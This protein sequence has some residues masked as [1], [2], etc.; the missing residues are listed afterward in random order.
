MNRQQAV[1]FLQTWDPDGPVELPDALV[2]VLETDTE[3]QAAFDARFARAPL[4]LVE[5][6]PPPPYRRPE[7]S[8]RIRPMLPGFALAAAALIAV[9]LV[10][11]APPENT[12]PLRAVPYEEVAQRSLAAPG[13]QDPAP[14][15][16]VLELP[17]AVWKEITS[18][19]QTQPPSQEVLQQLRQ[20][21]YLEG[22]EDAGRLVA[23]QLYMH[24]EAARFS[25]DAAGV[26]ATH[27]AAF[28][29]DPS[30]AKNYAL[31]YSWDSMG[32][33]TAG[34]SFNR[35][36]GAE[37]NSW[38]RGD[39]PGQ[40]PV[41]ATT[42][43]AVST[44]G[45]DVDTA[46]WPRARH[47]LNRA[48]IPPAAI[49]RTE[50]FLNRIPYDYAAPRGLPF[51]AIIGVA[52]SPW[53]QGRHVL[54]VGVATRQVSAW[55]RKP[56]HL[57]FLV[58]TSGSMDE[59][60]K[61]GLV[62]SSLSTLARQ[63]RPDDTVA[64]VAYAAGVVLPPTPMRER[65]IVLSAIERL[66]AGGSTAMG[67]GIQVAYDLAE[68]TYQPGAVNRVVLASDGDANVG[69]TTH[70]PLTEA[71]RHYADQ[72]ITL[73]VV[74]VGGDS[75]NGTLMENLAQD[76]DGFYAWLDGPEEA[77]RIF[78]DQL[79]SSMEVVARD[80]KAQVTFD[81]ARVR[82]WRQ[83]GYENRALMDYEFVDDAVDAGEIG[84][85]HQV[86]VLYELELVEGGSGPLGTV[87]L[88]AKPP[89][90]DAAASQWEADIPGHAVRD[91]LEHT[92]A[93]MQIAVAAAQVAELFRRIR[94][95]S[96][97]EWHEVVAAVRKAARQGVDEDAELLWMAERAL[98]LS[99]R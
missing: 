38:L 22:G 86:T 24:D 84:A 13:P 45:L 6:P 20:L 95:V 57:T 77:E 88:R 58:D 66:S 31:T 11:T 16:V 37:G 53:H 85:G 62:Q 93:D 18:A 5:D 80:A 89:G 34:P 21:G 30:S 78:V 79:T 48:Q 23:T 64:L 42:E 65:D 32:R 41:V 74:G 44:F 33:V 61:L 69:P 10:E 75:Y 35:Y 73:T 12:L 98:E 81:P 43:D 83:V 28:T 60:D 26:T 9:G 51:S 17:E 19:H 76:G 67:A 82:S 1:A 50:A 71:I 99:Q 3:V 2:D 46:A 54:R 91:A 29:R 8:R 90:P 4:E 25:D 63:L 49:M 72:G 56:V 59:P 15:E 39:D 96:P 92:D 14:D 27:D 70:G 52:P 68:K 87:S 55:F 40:H 36:A 97:G 7:R 47:H 94:P